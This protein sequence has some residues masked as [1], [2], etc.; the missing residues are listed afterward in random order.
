MCY[1]KKVKGFEYRLYNK[2]V[3][4][5]KKYILD[6]KWCKTVFK[7][8]P[9]YK[10]IIEEYD[11][12]RRDKNYNLINLLKIIY[13]KFGKLNEYKY[14]RM[15]DN[16]K[17]ECEDEDYFY[18]YLYESEKE[19]VLKYLRYMYDNDDDHDN[20]IEDLRYMYGEE[21]EEEEEEILRYISGVEEE[22]ILRYISG[23]RSVTLEELRYMY[24]I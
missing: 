21:E 2:S 11:E 10:R 7:K 16:V 13:E 17:C 6:H 19:N 24:G 23:V 18:N 15:F 9:V 12:R 20:V 1:I 22:E 14:I 4:I 8:Y 5:F 3:E